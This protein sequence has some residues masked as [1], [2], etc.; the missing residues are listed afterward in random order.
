MLSVEG[1]A[2]RVVYAYHCVYQLVIVVRLRT[3]RDLAYAK[4]A[5]ATMIQR[6]PKCVVPHD[7]FC[8]PFCAAWLELDV[9]LRGLGFWLMFAR[10]RIF[11]TIVIVY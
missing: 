9:P 5:S 2:R 10:F 8:A 3:A 7:C 6:S 11:R 1:S 4:T